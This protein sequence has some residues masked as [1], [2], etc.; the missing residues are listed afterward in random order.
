MRI[1][2]TRHGQVAPKGYYGNDPSLPVGDVALTPLGKE[3]ARLTGERLKELGFKGV[4]FSS[5]YDR[6]L[7]TASIIA[8]ILDLTVIPVAWLHEIQM[9]PD[10]GFCGA[11]AEEIRRSYP[12][13]QDDFE[14]PQ[15]WWGNETEDLFAVI[16]RVKNGLEPVLPT[17]PKDLDVLLVGHA[18]TSVALRHLFHCAQDNRA[19][20]WNCHLSL[21]QSPTGECYANDCSHLPEEMWTGNS[22]YY[23]AQRQ[24]VLEGIRAAQLQGKKEVVLHIGDI[25]SGD[26]GYAKL[27]I[28]EIKPDVIIHTGDLADE[29][30]AGRI[31]AVRP[32]WCT[33]AKEL[34]KMMEGSGAQV[35]IVPG[36]N[37]PE[38][39]LKKMV[40]TA[41]IVPRNTVLNFGGT[42]VLLCH[43][44]NRMD[45][46]ADADVFLYGHGL[47]GETR[48]AEDNVRD[49]KQFFNAIW[50]AF[51][52]V[53]DKN[54]HHVVPRVHL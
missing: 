33:A 11:T 43:E 42:K 6:T 41:R 3:Q 51:V 31:E 27:L 53:F 9:T 26:Y 2:E 21:L 22:L 20:H 13:V 52:H 17:I 37:D 19:F 28:D 30:K 8:E 4:I 40:T 44:L 24:I 5:P 10:D 15:C 25:A 50:G 29:L 38:E 32:Y 34:V 45:E 18:A 36:N 54:E 23:T 46:T 47:T 7:K 16:E 1:F 49:G 14:L 35:V 48:T 39:E 12:R